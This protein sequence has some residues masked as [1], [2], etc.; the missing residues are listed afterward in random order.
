MFI[1][2]GGNRNWQNNLYNILSYW[3]NYIY[4]INVCRYGSELKCVEYVLEYLKK[5]SFIYSFKLN[6]DYHPTFPPILENL[7]LRF[8]VTQTLLNLRQLVQVLPSPCSFLASLVL[9]WT[10]VS[11]WN[12][13]KW[14]LVLCY[15][16]L[17]PGLCSSSYLVPII[18]SGICCKCLWSCPGC[19]LR[20]PCTLCL[21]CLN[22]FSA[23]LGL[24]TGV[25]GGGGSLRCFLTSERILSALQSPPS[26]W[27]LCPL[28]YKVW[29]GATW[30]NLHHKKRGSSIFCFHILTK[31]IYN[32]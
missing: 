11:S 28:R 24:I 17:F 32:S 13:E 14:H 1:I 16:L 23:H 26:L 3:K 19:Q 20:S 6:L 12:P 15:S 18:S 2:F 31:P 5:L 8:K 9:S 7:I 4:V 25:H 21:P 29:H 27:L 22:S 10:D 30:T